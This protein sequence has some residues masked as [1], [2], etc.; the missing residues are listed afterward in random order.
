M[1]LGIVPVSWFV[2]MSL[3]ASSSDL[4]Q[5]IGTSSHRNVNAVLPRLLGSVPV[6]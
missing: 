1:L 2:L 5:N 6:S 4:W 3:Q